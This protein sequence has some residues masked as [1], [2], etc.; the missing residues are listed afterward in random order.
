MKTLNSYDD[1]DNDI[2]RI[3]VMKKNRARLLMVLSPY[4]GEWKLL[5]LSYSNILN[6]IRRK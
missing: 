4:V 3:L 6:R 5:F 2:E 1:Y